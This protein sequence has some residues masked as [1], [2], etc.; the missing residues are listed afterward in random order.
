M[1]HCGSPVRIWKYLCWSQSGNYKVW[2]IYG[3]ANNNQTGVV[4]GM[5]W[6]TVYQHSTCLSFAV[7]GKSNVGSISVL[8][9]PSIYRLFV[10]LLI[11]WHLFHYCYIN[12]SFTLWM[13]LEY[14]DENAKRIAWNSHGGAVVSTVASQQSGCAL[15]Q[16]RNMHVRQTGNSKLPL[17]V[18]MVG[19][20]A[21][22]GPMINWW[23][24]QESGHRK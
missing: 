4:S 9:Q 3:T 7:H 24:A 13:S 19:L 11:C 15:P 17:A 8:A 21:V 23:L 5:V 22:C 2:G 1:S 12:N 14:G 6:C 16:P 10:C 20:S 18:R